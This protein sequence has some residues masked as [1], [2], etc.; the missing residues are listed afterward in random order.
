MVNHFLQKGHLILAFQNQAGQ[1]AWKPPAIIKRVTRK[2][3]PRLL[4]SA[5]NGGKMMHNIALPTLIV[6]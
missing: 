6:S 3:A 4:G 1:N 5:D 2:M